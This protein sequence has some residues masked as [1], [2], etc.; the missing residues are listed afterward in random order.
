MFTTIT[1]TLNI[2]FIIFYFINLLF[3]LIFYFE[4]VLCSLS[5]SLSLHFFLLSCNSTSVEDFLYFLISILF[6]DTFWC[7]VVFFELP[8]KSPVSFSYSFSLIFDWVNPYIYIYIYGFSMFGVLLPYWIR[9]IRRM[10]LPLPR[11]RLTWC[12]FVFRS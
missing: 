6:V 8:I 2:L 12:Y 3:S 11:V 10:R 9:T 1:F 7:C 5:L 4:K